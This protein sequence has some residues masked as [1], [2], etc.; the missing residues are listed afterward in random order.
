MRIGKR[1]LEGDSFAE[2]AKNL[3]TDKVHVYKSDVARFEKDERETSLLVL[4][5]YA[6]MTNLT[7]DHFANDSKDLPF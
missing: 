2:M 3:T 7:I 4:V 6:R 1:I 5:E